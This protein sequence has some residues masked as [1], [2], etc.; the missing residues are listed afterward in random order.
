MKSVARL[1][2]T[3]LMAIVVGACASTTPIDGP[4][5]LTAA[6]PLSP[7]EVEVE[8]ATRRAEP[9]EWAMRQADLRATLITPRLRAAFAAD[10]SRF[11]GRFANDT[12]RELVS[13]GVVDEGVDA[14]AL[15]GPKGEE[16]VLVFIAFYAADQRNRDL[17][18]KG[19]IWDV[20]LVRGA[21]RVKPIAI[22]PVRS[23]PAVAEV[24]P[25][26]DRFDDLYLLRFPLVDPATGFSPLTPGKEPLRLEIASAVTTCAVSWSLVD[27]SR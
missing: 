3:G 4:V 27:G 5:G 17:A 14:T 6:A 21:V 1:L 20:A 22:E 26:V 16:Q 8:R 24:F 7:W 13:F 10:R 9:Y 18:I 15:A 19:S 2:A 12:A 25:F 23:S 11:H